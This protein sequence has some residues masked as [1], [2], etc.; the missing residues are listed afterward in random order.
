[1]LWIV[2]LLTASGSV[3]AADTLQDVSVR[4][5]DDQRVEI[6][7]DLAAG[8]AQVTS[9]NLNDPPRIVV[10]LKDTR[11]GI[12]PT[13]RPIGT[14]IVKGLRT[15]D[16]G[17]R[18]RIVVDLTQAATERVRTDGTTVIV[19]IMP[20]DGTAAPSPSTR[21]APP[22]A[23]NR[24]PTVSDIDFRRGDAGQARI[25][26]TLS[27]PTIPV[28][29]QRV[30]RTIVT[31]F[32][33]AALAD[34]L[35]RRL[36]VTDFGTPVTF[37]DSF[38]HEGNVRLVIETTGEFSHL[39]FQVGPV[40]TIE[41]RRESV[42]TEATDPAELE[43]TGDR[44]SL[45]FQDID[46][47]AALDIIADFTGLNVV[48]DDAVSGRITLRLKEVPWD[49]ALDVILQSQGLA[50]RRTGNV[51]LVA[52][53]DQLS[54][55]ERVELESRSQLSE[56]APIRSEVFKIRYARAEDLAELIAGQALR[57]EQ[58]N[59]LTAGPQLL[60]ARGLV[61]PDARTN[62]LIIYETAE[63]L[64]DIRELIERLDVPVR[65]VMIESRIVSVANTYFESLGVQFGA[66]VND[67]SLSPGGIPE[68]A[69]GGGTVPGTLKPPAVTGF[70][71]P[72]GSGLE[73][74]IS[75]FPA[76]GAAGVSPAAVQLVLGKV[77]TRLLQLELSALQQDG[78]A[79]VISS[80][81]VV[82]ADQQTAFISQG[83]LIPF[84]ESAG[85]SGATSTS[86]QEATLSLNVTPRITPD[87]RINMRLEV[88]DDSPTPVGQAVGI[89]TRRITTE[90]LVN[91]GDTVVLGG[92]LREDK[93]KSVNKIPLLGDIPVLGV[94]FRNTKDDSQKSEL[95][96]F[97]T[98]TVM[99]QE[100][101]R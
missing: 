97:I 99:P 40:Y 50:M 7:L 5:L 21:D 76:S 52:P 100:P 19:E 26:V 66:A 84:Q 77:G 2:V 73:G 75:S 3:T 80:P 67:F 94:L 38:A 60:T 85:A 35:E 62:T 8:T 101:P 42:V 41:V 95:M 49:Q 23:D 55:R 31:Q 45:S 44:L 96:V 82:T 69:V 43:Y 90:V 37:I 54:A 4:A 22:P 47:R 48:V 11:V 89:N 93:R 74:L 65:Q 53:A 27:E 51:I 9:F 71:S 88:S 34:R 13:S 25:L 59:T 1:M 61:I 17:G 58:E 33:N 28:D 24:G 70:E 14:G 18:T 86:F 30:G 16:A 72:G 81:R 15:I 91:N 92:I 32:A 63:R 98:P 46:G 87:E 57:P 20:R 56:L 64:A 6:A 12:E 68:G 39:G 10:D 29:I 79:E 78:R 83:T 36:D